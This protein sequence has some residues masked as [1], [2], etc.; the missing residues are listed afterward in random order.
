MLAFLDNPI[1]LAVIVVLALLLFGPEKLPQIANQLGRALRELRRTTSDLRSSLEMDDRYEP[2][3]DPPRYDSYGNSVSYTDAPAAVVP[4]ENTWQPPT[5]EANAQAAL[6]AAEPPRG[7]FAAA[8]LSDASS[9]YGVGL[10]SSRVPDGGTGEKP[11]EGPA[12]RPAEST[13]P[14]NRH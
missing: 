12:P 4:E 7:D 8:A 6:T 3:Y 9:E 11:I 2:H 5:P 10:A 14:H 1:A 13:V